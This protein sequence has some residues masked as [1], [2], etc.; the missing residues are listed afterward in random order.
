MRADITAAFE[1]LSDEL[2]QR[3]E[4]A[5]I[6][7]VGGAALVLLFGARET[8]KDVD[9]CFVKPEAS[10]IR[11]AAARVADRL[12]SRRTPGGILLRM[13]AACGC[14][15]ADG[16]HRSACSSSILA[17]GPQSVGNRVSG[18]GSRHGV[19]GAVTAPHRVIE[20]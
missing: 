2:G 10:R 7:V 6:V 4:R 8:T 11:N 9:A 15:L 13:V 12:G 17:S 5:E 18:C 16:F 14:E 19:S 1:A 3:S 20:S